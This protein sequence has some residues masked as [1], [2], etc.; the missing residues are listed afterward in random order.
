MTKK[1]LL[2]TAVFALL[3]IALLIPA[4]GVLAQ[5]TSDPTTFRI[6]EWGFY[7]WPGSGIY[8]GIPAQELNDILGTYLDIEIVPNGIPYGDVYPLGPVLA[9]RYY[10]NFW[11][12]GVNYNRN[13]L[14][15]E[16]ADNWASICFPV[17]QNML[18]H[19]EGDPYRLSI[20]WARDHGKKWWPIKTYYNPDYE[21]LCII[22]RDITGIY[23][24][25]DMKYYGYPW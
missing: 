23:S 2:I 25:V 19:A 20:A 5:G 8:V 14:L 1:R 17:D 6:R 7:Y 18:R 21:T 22:D 13:I 12:A 3:I 11:D 15:G 4:G 9:M 16:K 24:V 10:E